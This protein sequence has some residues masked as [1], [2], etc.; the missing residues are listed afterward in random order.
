MLIIELHKW[1]EHHV[2]G[3]VEHIC[4][5]IV[6]SL[7]WY[8]HLLP[9]ANPPNTVQLFPIIWVRYDDMPIAVH[10]STTTPGGGSQRMKLDGTAASSSP[11]RRSMI[12][13]SWLQQLKANGRTAGLH[14]ACRLACLPLSD[15]TLCMHR[16]LLYH[17][18]RRPL[19]S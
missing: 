14:A 16:L 9:L 19:I 18:Y 8:H 15:C 1:R 11:L 3:G 2:M 12:L 5:D 10:L 7:Y 13:H 6:P 17:P 4:T